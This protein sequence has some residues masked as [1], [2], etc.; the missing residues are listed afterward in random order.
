MVS[1]SNLEPYCFPRIRS[2]SISN[3]G[4]HGYDFFLLPN[5]IAIHIRDWQATDMIN[6][7]YDLFAPLTSPEY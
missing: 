5:H 7:I 6:A 3:V 1:I 4:E 2:V